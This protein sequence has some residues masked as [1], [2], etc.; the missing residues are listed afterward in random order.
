MAFINIFL[1]KPAKLNIKNKQLEII[2]EITKTFPIEDINSIVIDSLQV[3]ITAYTLSEL[4]ENQVAIVM[5][6]QQH[7]PNGIMLPC[8]QHSRQ[9][10]ILK[11]QMELPIPI[12]KQLWQQIIKQK[13]LN[14]SKVLKILG[15]SGF[16]KLEDYSKSVLSNDSTNLEATAANFYFKRL[17]GEDFART[18]NNLTNASL[19]YG[20]TILRSIIARTLLAYGL[21]PVMGL[22]HKSE[23]NNFNLADDIIEPFRPVVDLFVAQNKDFFESEDLTPKL[24]ASL[25]NLLNVNILLNEKEYN[26]SY[27]IEEMIKSL[28]NAIIYKKGEIELPTILDLKL[29]SYE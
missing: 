2:S 17:F 3:N 11:N 18:Q 7:I 14:Q 15:L 5:C 28:Q 13:I 16:E 4:I 19:N 12:K 29:H 9:L 20:Y 21:E 22:F 26:V 25:V 8:N 10:K 24:K 1:S 6:N 23:L 27:A